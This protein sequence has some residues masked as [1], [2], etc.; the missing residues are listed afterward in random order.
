LTRM[1]APGSAREVLLKG[2]PKSVRFAIL[3][4]ILLEALIVSGIFMLHTYEDKTEQALRDMYQLK[5]QTSRL[6]SIK[7]QAIAGRKIE[8]GVNEGIK[9]TEENMALIITRLFLFGE[10]DNRLLKMLSFY[11][12]YEMARDGEF[13]LIRRGEFEDAKRMDRE[14]TDPAFATLRTNINENI[15][16]YTRRAN[17]V[18]T[19]VDFFTSLLFILSGFFIAVLIIKTQKTAEKYKLIKLE[20][21]LRK[22]ARADQARLFEA[23]ESSTDAVLIATKEG[24]IEYVN[25]AF[26][27]MTGYS[28][29]EVLGRD[30]DILG[31]NGGKYEP[32]SEIL[33]HLGPDQHW[34]GRLANRRKSG[35]PFQSEDTIAAVGS[36]PE[37]GFVVIKRDLTEKLRLESIAEAVNTMNNIGYVFSGIRHEIG[38]PINSI[39]ANLELMKKKL[40]AGNNNIIENLSRSQSELARIE[41]LLLA[42]KN[43]NM[44]EALHPSEIE[45]RPFVTNFSKL[46]TEDFGRKGIRLTVELEEAAGS[47]RADPRALQQVLLNIVTN[48]ADALEGVKE[49][50]IALAVT[51]ADPD[52]VRIRVA[53]NGQG[54][55]DEQ[56]KE[57][58][59]PFYTTKPHGTGL[60]LVLSKKMV[61]K[62]GGYLKIDGS[63]G[64]GTNVDIFLPKK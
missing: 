16:I 8:P 57:I 3:A 52:M 34:T 59:K 24:R 5:T 11:T 15:A 41:Y 55:S 47:V 26:E 37:S 36:S 21:K 1:K 23:I 63:P 35:E 7:W 49:P 42:L 45:V 10:D 19:L 58:F 51:A 43:F 61:S 60:G 30:L 38:N 27:G 25:T 6:N 48:A 31:T 17:R 28:K 53:D 12:V 50:R 46:M 33:A 14:Q 39:K 56:K 20:H 9:E 32:Y 29:G 18:G 62:M 54:L 13:M 40:E 64:Q 44:Y 2:K 22:E 4:I